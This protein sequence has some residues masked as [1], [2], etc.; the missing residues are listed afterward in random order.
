VEVAPFQDALKIRVSAFKITIGKF[1][2]DDTADITA[3][4]RVIGWLERVRGER[5]KSVSSYARVSF[6]SHY[7]IV[8]TDE[9]AFRQLHKQ[10]VASRTEASFEVERAL[11]RAWQQ[12]APVK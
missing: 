9:N 4:G 11:E 6:V 3:D 5:F 2:D 10:D 1:S 7:S 8:L 12:Q